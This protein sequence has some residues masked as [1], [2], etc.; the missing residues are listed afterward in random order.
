MKKIFLFLLLLVAGASSYA[1]KSY[2]NLHATQLSN[3]TNQ[4]CYLTGDI[5]EGMSS[6]IA[7][8]VGNILN[9]LAQEGYEV[10]FMSSS[11]TSISASSFISTVNYLLSKKTSSTNPDDPGIIT[12]QRDISVDTEAYEVAR[13]NLQGLPV[14]KEEKGVQIVVYSN[15]TTKTIIVE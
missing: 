8:K 11:A 12:Y 1:Q 4:Y 15:Y 7:D 2:I 14:N 9:L 5:P 3:P 10:E 13:Y 6:Y